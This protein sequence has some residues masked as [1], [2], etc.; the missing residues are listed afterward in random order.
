MSVRQDKVQIQIE[1]ITDESKAFAKTIQETERY[2]GELRKAQ[3][4]VENLGKEQERLA[5]KGKDTTQVALKLAEAEK[6]VADNLLKIA[7]SGKSV[8]KIDLSKLM[9]SQ[10]AA[11]ATQLRQALQF[12]PEGH[13]QRVQME[14][15]LQAINQRLAEMNARTKAAGGGIS[16]GGDGGG[17]GFLSGSVAKFAGWIGVAIGVVRG[18]WAAISSGVNAAAT[19]EQT[20]VSFEVLAGGA[21]EAKKLVKDLFDFAAKTPFEISP[22]NEA[23]KKL[24]AYGFSA[25]E[26]VP[27]LRKIGDVAAA[28]GVPIDELA[29]IFGKAKLGN[30][31]Q[32]EEL[33]QLADR[34]IPVFESLAKQLGVS[35]SQV[36]Q[37]GSDGKITFKNLEKAFDE[38]TG[39]GGRFNGMMDKQ[40]NT[41]NG[42]LSTLKDNV[43]QLLSTVFA[44][45]VEGL[46]P[47]L[48]F[49]IDVF[50]GA[51]KSVKGFYVSSSATWAAFKAGAAQAV[52]NVKAYFENLWISAQLLQK[53]LAL[54]LSL[55]NDRSNII[56]GEIQRL[57]ELKKVSAK[58]GKSAGDAFTEAYYKAIAEAGKEDKAKAK[59]QKPIESIK[60]T[61]KELKQAAEELKDHYDLLLKEADLRYKKESVINDKAFFDKQK[62]ESDANKKELELKAILYNEQIALLNGYLLKVKKGGEEYVDTQI[63]IL[64]TEKKL[65]ETRAELRPR[66]ATVT[67]ALP[68]LSVRGVTSQTDGIGAIQAQ[69]ELEKSVVRQKF[70]DILNFELEFEIKRLEIQSNA[71]TRQLELLKERGATE[72]DEYKRIA[73][74]KIETDN[75]ISDNKKRLSDLEKDLDNQKRE[76]TRQAFDVAIDLLSKDEAARKKNASAIKAFQI[77]QVVADGIMEVQ[78][79]WRNANANPLNILIPGIGNILAGVQTALA[80]GR[81][82]AAVQ[83]IRATKFAKGGFTGFGTERDETGYKVAGIVHEGEYVL[84]K[85]MVQ[86]PKFQPTIAALESER[87]RGFALGGYVDTTP[88]LSSIYTPSVVGLNTDNLSAKLDAYMQKMDN[89]ANSLTVQLPLTDL[90]RKQNQKAVDLLDAQF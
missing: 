87:M 12:I 79:L 81:T 90:E 82:T 30:F 50:E 53:R 63:K 72:T 40:S 11:R 10:L 22:I 59:A 69:A 31:I 13:P 38:L 17:F 9:P 29:M 4:D 33:N 60:P 71:Y 80:I 68:T 76:L 47:V 62:S 84:P 14:K 70:A 7:E 37:M 3:K 55:N 46:K 77:G 56:R 39:A 73:K 26:I 67:A 6:K 8:E 15:D 57:E 52:E 78:A 58:G 36:K 35:V 16:A 24:L 75:N 42:L 86:N 41:F 85:W 48:R 28:V 88:R 74:A 45:L 27:K 21:A 65:A 25:D 18:L 54:A 89:W 83:R 51:T 19:L 23:A 5:A 61:E 32:A 66:T 49:L 64:E 2:R 43:G 20:A 44:P 34:G 1:F